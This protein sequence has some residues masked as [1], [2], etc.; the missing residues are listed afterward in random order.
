MIIPPYL[1]RGDT[2]GFV[3]PAR[4]IS[5]AELEASIHFLEEFDFRVIYDQSLFA[6]AHQFAGNDEIRRSGFQKMLDRK[7]VSAIWCVRGGYGSAR[8][9]DQ[10]DFSTFCKHPKW[11]CGFSD[12]TVFH[13]HIHQN[14]GIATLH[15]LMPINVNQ[16]NS[17]QLPPQL[18]VQLL[19]GGAMDYTIESHPLNREGEAKGI[20]VGGNLSILYSLNGTI[21]DLDTRNKILFME[22]LDEYLYHIDRMMLNLKRSGK[23]EGIKGLIIGGMSEMRDNTIPFG[24]DA[25]HIIRHHCELYDFPICFGFPAGH[26]Q[27]NRPL[28]LGAL[29]DL[30]VS[31]NG[32]SLIEK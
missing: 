27:D 17:L 26:I 9:I 25:E 5:F 31:K 14:F 12:V 23:L 30:K 8:I 10:L 19:M 6:E 22:D 15:S 11:I 32:S 20:L 7:D 29:V 3:A 24:I 1:K 2:I 18:M 21:S 4:K 28:K 16:E 13:S